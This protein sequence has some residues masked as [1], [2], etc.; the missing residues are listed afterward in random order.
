MRVSTAEKRD[1]DTLKTSINQSEILR[2]TLTHSPLELSKKAKNKS[3]SMPLRRGKWTQEEED[4]ANRLIKEF[5]AGLLP[6]DDGT[7]LRNFLSKVSL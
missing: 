2:P 7:T 3:S 6:L 1:E 5:K 4:Y